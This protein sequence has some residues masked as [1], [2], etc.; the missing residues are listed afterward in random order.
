M[1]TSR[2]NL[3]GSLLESSKPAQLLEIVAVFGAAALLI[4]F[5]LPFAGDDLF[6]KQL[7]VVAAN[8]VMLFMVWLGLRMRGQKPLSLGLSA[9]FE[10]WKSMAW[11]FAKSL[12]VL[13]MAMAGFMLGSII[14]LNL[15]GL[16]QQADVSG[17]DYLQG[18]PALFLVSLASIYFFSSFGEEVVYRGFLI[19]RLETLF[20]PGRRALA[21]AVVFSSLVFGLAHFGWGVAGMVQ[22]T[23][24]GLA[25]AI[26]FVIFKRRLWI[27]VAAHA[28]MD[29]ALILPLYFGQP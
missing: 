19:T 20:G 12:L 1:P 27:L 10:G 6:A 25:L 11:G 29:T 24:M 22:T 16:P 14:M 17:Y 3:L 26:S 2:L 15:T 23:F 8:A 13:V 18:N 21:W 4:A 9:H 7:V 28:Y 5:G